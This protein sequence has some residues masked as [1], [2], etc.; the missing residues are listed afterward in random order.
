MTI[1]IQDETTEDLMT[2]FKRWRRVI[3]PLEGDI[4][5]HVEVKGELARR[6]LGSLSWPG[7]FMELM[8]K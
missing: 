8:D 6:M 5:R 7:I 1:A 2:E 4:A 3:A